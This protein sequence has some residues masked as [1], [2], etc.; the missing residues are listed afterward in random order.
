MTTA[1]T[2]KTW[3]RTSVQNLVRHKSGRYYARLFANGKESWKT[4][5]TDLLEVAKVKLRELTGTA[6]KILRA[7]TALDRGRMSVEDCATVLE[8]RVEQGYGL[9]G[10]GRRLNQ[11]SPLTQKYRLETIVSLWRTWPELRKLDARKVTTV[12]IE[13]WAEKF[14]KEYSATRYNATLDTLRMLFRIAQDAGACVDNPAERIGRMTVKPKTLVLPERKQFQTLV[15]TVRTAGGRFSKNCADYI[16]FLAFTGARKNEA[17]NLLWS[18]V[19]L[20]GNRIHLRITKGGRSRHVD[21]IA[22]AISLLQRLQI[23]RDD[24]ADDAAVLR[25][26]EAQKAID[27]AVKRCGIGRITHHDLRHLFATTCIE[28]GV[29]IPTVSRWLGHRDGGALAM[30][31]YGHLRNE[32]SAAQAQKVSFAALA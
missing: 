2:V 10:K 32:H 9:K 31:T 11:I 15:T 18:D 7:T 26:N 1:P 19:D 27:R 29:D 24:N 5:K 23:E 6:E 21:L 4:L 25:V 28:A 17:A 8:K 13:N 20:I 22:D 16:E 30:R 3:T 12:A 14:A